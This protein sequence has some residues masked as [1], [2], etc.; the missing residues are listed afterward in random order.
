MFEPHSGHVGE[1]SFVRLYL[2]FLQWVSDE[3]FFPIRPLMRRRMG[4]MKVKRMIGRAM[5]DMFISF[6]EC[7]VICC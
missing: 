5:M 3:I 2:H 1:V 7:A 6:C 4:I